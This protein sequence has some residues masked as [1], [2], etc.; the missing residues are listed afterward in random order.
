MCTYNYVEF[1][2]P[3]HN[4]FYFGPPRLSRV[5]PPLNTIAKLEQKVVIKTVWPIQNDH[6]DLSCTRLSFV[7][8]YKFAFD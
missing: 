5:P 6:A 3:I 8:V 1:Q 7:V 4:S 2:E